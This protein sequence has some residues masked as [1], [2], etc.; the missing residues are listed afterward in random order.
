MSQG[1]AAQGY[2]EA[3]TRTVSVA[4]ADSVFREL[5]PRA[6]VPLVLT[7]ASGGGDL[8]SWDFRI[9]DGFVRGRWVFAVACRGVGYS[10]SRVRDPI[11]EMASEVVTVLRALGHDRVDMFGLSMGGMVAQVVAVQALGLMDRLILAGSV[12]LHPHPGR[13]GRCTSGRRPVA[14]THDRARQAGHPRH[15]SGAAERGAP[16]GATAGRPGARHR[17]C[18][19]RPWGQRPDGA[20]RER[21]RTGPPPA[22]CG[23][24]G[25]SGL[26][27]RRRFHNHHAFVYAA[28]DFPVRWRPTHAKLI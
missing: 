13:Q 18:A 3:S 20:A 25:V 12:V 15:L 9:V 6:N 16:V 23:G 28:R 11:E 2:W 10:T 5:G 14:G 27:A 21:H 26:R 4:D 24:H 1:R 7:D 19:H 22:R 8:D 17:P